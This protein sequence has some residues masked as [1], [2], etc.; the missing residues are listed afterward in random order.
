MYVSS[1]V[2]SLIE[3]PWADPM[4]ARRGN[5][6]RALFDRYLTGSTLTVSDD[7]D[8]D[9][10]LKRL[11]PLDAEIW[12][13]RMVKQRPAVRVFGSFIKQDMFVALT[14]ATRFELGEIDSEEWT[15][16]LRQ[17]THEW[18]KLFHAYIPFSGA[19]FDAYLSRNLPL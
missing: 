5:A 14:W 18:Q 3:G 13:F 17:Y 1:D 11:T 10:N 2:Y 8:I 16:A 9:V 19:N 15:L 12:Q 6:V 7:K 4:D